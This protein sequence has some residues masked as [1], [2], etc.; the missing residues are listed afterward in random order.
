M[1]MFRYLFT[2]SLLFTAGFAA[3]QGWERVYDGGGGGQV[4]DIVLSPDGGFVMVGYYNLQNRARLFKTDADGSLQWTKDFF[5][6]SLTTAEAVVST[7]DKGYAIAGFFKTGTDPKQAY[8]LKTDLSGNTVW[9]KK[10]GTQY[11]AEGLDLVELAD[12]SLALCG[13]QKNF[14]GKEDVWV[15]KTDA[16]GNISWS[17]IYGEPTVSEK[18]YGI[19][20]ATDGNF[21]VAGEKGSVPSRDIYV[22][23]I[24]ATTG[25]VM[26]EN[27]YGLFDLQGIASDDAAR[28]VIY[29]TDGGIV[30]AGRST[31][32]QGGAGV[33]LKIDGSGNNN[34]ALW[35]QVYP[36][37]DFFGLTKSANGGFW[38]TGNKT[39][40]S[41]QEELHILR[42]DA[43]GDKIC[44]ILVG[45]AG[46]DRGYA[47]IATPDGGAA[48]AGSGEI[49]FPNATSSENPYLV[50]TDKNCLVFTSYLSGRVFH[51]FNAN[52]TTDANEPG[53]ENWIVKIESPNFTRYAVSKANGEF[54]LLVDTGS[55]KI[56]LFPP[57][58]YWTTCT[59]SITLPVTGFS[60][61]FPVQ[62]PV[63]ASFACPRNEVDLATP[64][65]RRCDDN[66]YTVRYCN[67]GTIP[68]VNTTIEVTL[69][70]YLSYVSSSIPPAG[71]PQGNTYTFN[72]GYL[73]NGD[74]GSFTLVAN[75][76]CNT[77]IKGQ[78]HC[79]KAHIFPDS[80]CNVAN[81]DHSV[82]MAMAT[83]EN[84][85]VKLGL[86]NI[87]SDDM[88]DFVGFVIAEDVIML[89]AP[90]DPMYQVQ[91]KQD[92]DTIVYT[93]PA[94][95]KT[96]RIIAE[97]TDG[98][99]GLSYPTAAVEGCKSDT[100]TTFSIGYYTMFPDDDAEA[101]KASDCQESYDTD[102]NPQYQKRG[103]PK[104]YDVPNYVD[105]TTDLEYLI[106]FQNTGTDTVHQVI[107]R[108]TLSPYLDPATVHP[109]AAS[110][111]YDFDVLGNG[112]V[113]FTLQN[114]NLPPG[115]SANEGYVKFRVSQKPALP[116]NTRIFNS[117]AISFD[118]DAPVVTN[119]TFHTICLIDTFA[120]VQ[121]KD[122]QLDGADIRVFPNPF[123]D[124][125]IFEV[126]GVNAPGFN[127]ELYDLQGKRVFNQ[128][129]NSPTFRLYRHHL[130][131]G[132]F[133]YRLTTEKGKPVASGKLLVR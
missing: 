101:F 119:Q 65:L 133:F 100:S 35:Q 86:K 81:W 48:S 53:L 63:H 51:D 12:G 87:G 116:C 21:V 29:D 128:S 97:Q 20:L 131:A 94:N 85:S 83:C 66:T 31:V 3:G 78:A 75:L 72:I 43:E 79:V 57:N 62:I 61:T 13:H 91:L 24:S 123:D 130:P 9:L 60:D 110:H 33:L 76:A 93:T 71:A 8:L 37:A 67:S 109:G 121:T 27:T 96:Y 104:G 122:I 80:F 52:C 89:T 34:N 5:I 28:D 56:Q 50:K 68:S 127:L 115:S 77:T 16:G 2:L 46:V 59:P 73:A 117:A 45:R 30:I 41:A 36:K 105:P 108:D 23:K 26:W 98:Y 88:D 19:A 10:I 38:V 15:V 18:G 103:H 58:D 92:Q 69:D 55:Y 106:Q 39:S 124:S 7:K 99:P 40:T 1:H 44:D 32:I 120:I 54:Q 74:C 90:G 42:T 102:F 6:G 49:F 84:D 111:A 14:T 22:L 118:F 114:L 113:Q 64:V 47:I 129:Y 70:P 125:A 82:V 17:K 11:D 95:G 25:D 112:I 107:I 126:T 4:N 132:M